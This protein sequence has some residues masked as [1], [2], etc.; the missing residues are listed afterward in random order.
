MMTEYEKTQMHE[1]KDDFLK[2]T[3]E[4]IAKKRKY[5]NLTQKELGEYLEVAA[6]TVSRYESGEIEIPGS[7]LAVISSVC[8]FP[9]REYCTAWDSLELK[10]ILKNSLELIK[11]GKQRVRKDYT[12]HMSYSDVSF[13]R[14]Y[15]ELYPETEGPDEKEIE[16]MISLCT[17][18][19]KEDIIVLGTALERLENE[20]LQQKLTIMMIEEQLSRFTESGMKERA[21]R[22]YEMYT[23]RML[24]K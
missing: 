19:D 17:E 2:E 22:Y 13:V 8:G 12:S 1:I 21:I 23:K 14:E 10:D 16:L 3:G 7:N 11:R 20:D 24:G 15:Q 6:T 5:R 9:M 18:D 4:F